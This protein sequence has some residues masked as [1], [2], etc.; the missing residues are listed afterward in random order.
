MQFWLPG[1]PSKET[2]FTHFM[3]SPYRFL[4]ASAH[5]FKAHKIN[6]SLKF[7]SL[8]AKKCWNRKCWNDVNNLVAEDEAPPTSQNLLVS[9]GL[10][11]TSFLMQANHACRL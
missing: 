2:M 1:Y 10:T 9:F 5:D 3:I 8:A 6:T 7:A 4:E 11:L